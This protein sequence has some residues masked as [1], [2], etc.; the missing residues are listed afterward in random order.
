MV[1][2][3]FVLTIYQQMIYWMMGSSVACILSTSEYL[4]QSDGPCGCKAMVTMK[5][6]VLRFPGLLVIKNMYFS[7]VIRKKYSAPRY[8]H[9]ATGGKRNSHYWIMDMH[10]GRKESVY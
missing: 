4:R 3:I 2:P 10:G 8:R 6:T 7:I 9:N 5:V 1:N